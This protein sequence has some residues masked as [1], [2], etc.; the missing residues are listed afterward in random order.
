MHVLSIVWGWELVFQKKKK[1]HLM[2]YNNAPMI[3]LVKNTVFSAIILYYSILHSEFA[4]L[5]LA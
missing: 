3:L 2:L 1:T 4:S 5:E